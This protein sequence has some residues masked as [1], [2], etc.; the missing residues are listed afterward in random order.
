MN[1]S[2]KCFSCCQSSIPLA[3]T[4]SL[5]LNIC[6]FDYQLHVVTIA[7]TLTNMLS[8]LG[9]L[10]VIVALKLT[11]LVLNMFCT[12]IFWGHFL[13]LCYTL[14]QIIQG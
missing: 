10:D 5:S 4:N 14:E 11:S 12:S 13:D 3:L 1:K 7:T 8:I 2:C 9:D 6:C